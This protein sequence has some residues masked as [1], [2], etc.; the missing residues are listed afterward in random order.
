MIADRERMQSL[1]SMNLSNCTFSKK[2]IDTAGVTLLIFVIFGVSYSYICYIW[3]CIFIYLLYLAFHI[4]IF[5][6][7]DVSYSYICYI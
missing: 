5:V 3:R 2:H 7:F 6:I 1:S 4:H